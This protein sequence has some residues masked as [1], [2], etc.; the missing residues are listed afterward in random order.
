MYDP[1]R[2]LR[3]NLFGNVEPEVKLI[4]VSTPVELHDTGQ[5]LYEGVTTVNI[6][7]QVAKAAAVST[8][9]EPKDVSKLN[10]NLIALRH[11]TPLEAVQFSFHVSGISKACGAQISRH[12]IGQGHV[13]SSRRYQSQE[14]AFVYPILEK[15]TDPQTAAI[16]YDRLNDIYQASFLEY[17]RL[18]SMGIS[19]GDARYLVPVAS[20]QER[21]WWINARALRDFFGLR[22]HASAES[23]VRRLANLLLG[24][25]SVVTPTLFF[26][27]IEGS[28]VK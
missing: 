16:T 22:L 12:R 6:E 20:A 14:P 13:S 10:K 25:V 24:I 26:D 1:W 17:T 5:L 7:A 19:K 15:V 28:D 9:V 21:I 11:Y 2:H 8:G 18:R 27:F 4:S 3:E 23:E